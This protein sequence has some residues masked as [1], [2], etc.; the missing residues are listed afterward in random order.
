MTRWLTDD[1]QRA[2]RAWIAVSLLLPDR[3]SRELQERA[4]ISLPD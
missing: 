2:W 4:D 1:E 3:L